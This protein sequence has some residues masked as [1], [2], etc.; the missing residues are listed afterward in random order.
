MELSVLDK[1]RIFIPLRSNCTSSP[2]F[3][4]IYND[5][6]GVRIK[7]GLDLNKIIILKESEAY[8][9]IEPMDNSI[10]NKVF[11]D[12]LN[13]SAKIKAYCIKSLINFKKI[14]IKKKEGKLLN[15]KE[16]FIYDTS[17]LRNYRNIIMNLD[18]HLKM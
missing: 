5:K 1:Y 6:V 13:K 15:K 11:N 12:I 17:T 10:N 2:S 16:Q 3:I 9:Y 8:K 14:L 18:Q 7:P 4:P